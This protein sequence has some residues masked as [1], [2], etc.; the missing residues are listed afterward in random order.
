[1]NGRTVLITGCSSGFGRSMVHAF[2]EHGWRVIATMRDE[3]RRTNAILG[4]GPGPVHVLTLD[5]LSEVDRHAV[6]RFMAERCGGGLDCLV[7][8]AGYLLVG[9]LE[10]LSAA[11]ITRQIEVNLT[12]VAVLTS[13]L[14]P[15]L[16]QASGRVINISSVF[17][18][19]GF[20]LTSVYCASK[21]AVEGLSDALRQELRPHG[22][23]VSV[24]EPGRHHTRLGENAVWAEI[25][26]LT[27]PAYRLQYANY[28]RLRRRMQARPGASPDRVARAV[29]LLADKRR[30]P[31]RLRIGGDARLF[32]LMDRALPR[33]VT[34]WLLGQ[35]YRRV[36]L[37]PV[38]GDGQ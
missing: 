13:A 24:V 5:V 37:R 31:P 36:F 17:D 6:L 23:Q 25:G 9:A 29:R 38:E 33:S 11:Q 1:M 20:P 16:R 28:G 4:A 19:T 34:D 12:A 14:L 18:Y 30:M 21:Y 27:D 26:E 32:H 35:V 8:N 15:A 10:H 22:V 3:D 2:S 7:N